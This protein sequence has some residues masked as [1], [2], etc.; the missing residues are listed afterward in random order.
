MEKSLN[1]TKFLLRVKLWKIEKLG[2]LHAW[3]MSLLV[4]LLC[5]S[6]K[7]EAYQVDLSFDSL[8]PVTWYQ[9]GLESSVYV[10]QT[11]INVFDKSTDGATLSFDLLLGRLAFAQFCINRMNQE[12]MPCITDDSV[13]FASVLNKVQ[14]LLALVVITSKTHDFVVCAEDMIQAMQK[15][16]GVKQ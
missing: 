12:R 4:V 14:Q 2:N 15:K 9:K 16:L 8:F 5:T 10:W 11:L 6:S 7:I 1:P 13:Y 3:V